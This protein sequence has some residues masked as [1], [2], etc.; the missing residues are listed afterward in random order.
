MGLLLSSTA[1]LAGGLRVR[2]RLPLASDGV[3]LRE[4]AARVGTPLDELALRRALA[5]DPRQRMVV[6][7]LA[8]VG[9]ADLM[10]GAGTVDRGASPELL[11][12]DE[13]TAPGVGLLVE[14]ALAVWSRAGAL[15]AAAA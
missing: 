10:V 5:F 1:T 13:E 2:L 9:A 4:L 12:V 15:G 14:L 6:C 3:R 8:W 11:V 7:A